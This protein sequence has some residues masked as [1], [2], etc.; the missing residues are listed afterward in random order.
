M[1][2]TTTVA[3][4][5]AKTTT[6]TAAATASPGTVSAYSADRSIVKRYGKKINIGTHKLKIFICTCKHTIHILGFVKCWLTKDEY[7][8]IIFFQRLGR[9]GQTISIENQSP[10]Q[11]IPN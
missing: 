3:A 10:T 2:G 11:I 4:I 7:Q 9:D 5:T 8:I 1:L 6:T